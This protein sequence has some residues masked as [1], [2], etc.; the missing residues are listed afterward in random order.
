MADLNP[1]SRFQRETRER[2]LS[3]IGVYDSLIV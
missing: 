1:E 2:L 3:E